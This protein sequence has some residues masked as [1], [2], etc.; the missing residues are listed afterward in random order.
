[1]ENK[2]RGEKRIGIRFSWP[3][4][5]LRTPDVYQCIKCEKCFK[6][7]PNMNIKKI[8]SRAKL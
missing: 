1:M 5:T 7:K 6:M 3:V 8:R 4:F 2:R